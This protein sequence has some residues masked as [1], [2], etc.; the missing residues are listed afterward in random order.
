MLGLQQPAGMISTFN[1][2]IDAI[3]IQLIHPTLAT[4]ALVRRQTAQ[5]LW[6]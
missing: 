2:S 6:T 4:A 1:A 5:Q 3:N